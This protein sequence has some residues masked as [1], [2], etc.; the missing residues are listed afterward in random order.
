MTIKTI[1]LSVRI[2]AQDAEFIASLEF[3]E[4]VTPSDKLRA[5]IREARRRREKREEFSSCLG[6]MRGAVE[7]LFDR[8]K[9]EELRR[10]VYSELLAF[11]GEWLVNLLGYIASFS[12]HDEGEIDLEAIEEEL[13]TRIMRLISAVGRLSATSDAP[14]YNPQLITGKLLTIRE[15][16][17]LVQKRIDKEVGDEKRNC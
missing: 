4:A 17:D 9:A 11:F 15:I 12:P 5:L 2:S 8:I 3:E 10:D 6:L 14:C 13:C 7:P 16:I 1:P